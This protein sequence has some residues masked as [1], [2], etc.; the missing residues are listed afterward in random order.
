M[1]LTNIEPRHTKQECVAEATPQQKAAIP[2]AYQAQRSLTLAITDPDS[3]IVYYRI[4]DGLMSPDS[5]PSVQMEAP[6]EDNGQGPGKGKGLGRGRG[7]GKKGGKRK[8]GP[9]SEQPS[10]SVAEVT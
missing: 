1:F 7:K 2:P 8:G 9:G 10:R 3:S 6:E 5:G 4:S